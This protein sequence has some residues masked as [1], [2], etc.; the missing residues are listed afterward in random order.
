MFCQLFI[1]PGFYTLTL[2]L[3]LLSLAAFDDS[4]FC[5]HPSSQLL[6][7]N[8]AT[9]EAAKAK[10]THWLCGSKSHV[11]C[12]VCVVHLKLKHSPTLKTCTSIV[13][14]VS[15]TVFIL[16]ITPIT[17]YSFLAGCSCIISVCKNSSR[18][19]FHSQG[20]QAIKETWIR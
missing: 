19:T 5:F 12:F 15:P 7:V 18:S 20:R 8:I 9:I 17:V 2:M 10:G 11:L 16:L 3:C 14:L 13:F 1:T 6:P 4:P